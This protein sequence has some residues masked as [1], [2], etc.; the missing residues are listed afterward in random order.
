MQKHP[1]FPWWNNPIVKYLISTSHGTQGCPLWGLGGTAEPENGQSMPQILR[2]FLV[3]LSCEQH[4]VFPSWNYPVVEYSMTSHGT[5]GWSLG[6]FGDPQWPMGGHQ[7]LKMGK[8][9]QVREFCPPFLRATP[10]FPIVKYYI[11]TS[12]GTLGFPLGTILD[13]QGCLGA[14][15]SL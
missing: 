6:T 11:S 1:V 3:Q 12:H 8:I 9:W 10:S 2:Y 5:L 7:S 14:H 15:P 13:P 4:P